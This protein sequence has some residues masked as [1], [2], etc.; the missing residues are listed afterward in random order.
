MIIFPAIDLRKGRVVRLRQGRSDAETRYGDAPALIAERWQSEGAEWLHVV[1][2]DGAF[3]D[4]T[5]ANLRELKR[6]LAAVSV[7]VQFGG[8][9]RDTGSVEK[10]FDL[11]VKN[12]VLGTAAIDNPELVSEAVSR[13]GAERVVVG[14]DARD[15][16]VA[17]HGWRE[18]SK[19]R[20]SDL[21]RQMGD[22]GVTRIIYTD[23]ER[24]GMMKGIDAQA[25]AQFAREV[26]LRVIA[27]GGVA[28]MNDITTLAAY[29]D[30]EGVVVGQALYTGA[31]D[32][33]EAID[34]GKKNYSMP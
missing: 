5:F 23:I 7:P 9:L 31:V 4:D 16:M 10:A 20:A 30:I 6:I 17:T 34:A 8:G 12:V 19:I 24:D 1:N 13:F 29:P 21:A 3:G 28:S 27:S 25:L 2:L 15:G 18:E 14:I 22:R 33:R 26:G 11:G 32:L